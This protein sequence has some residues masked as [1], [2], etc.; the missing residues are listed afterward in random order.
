[1]S[2]ISLS[3]RGLQPGDLFGDYRIVAVAGKGGMGIV[4]KAVHVRLQRLV[5]LKLLRTDLSSDPEFQER[6]LREATL[7]ASIRRHENVVIVYDSGVEDDRLFLAMEWVDGDDLRSILDRDGPFPPVTAVAI[8]LQT[9]HALDAV[10]A[11]MVHRDVKPANIMISDASEAPHVYLTDFGVA[12]P[13]ISGKTLTQ[14]GVPVGTPGYL[15][16]EQALGRRVDQRSDLYS[17]GCVFFEA[18][19][20]WP[21]FSAN[22]DEELDRAH[23][24]STLPSLTPVLGSS[25]EPF[26]R[27]LTTALAIDPDRRQSSANEFAREL[28]AAAIEF[29]GM[30]DTSSVRGPDP[31]KRPTTNLSANIPVAST[32]HRNDVG[33]QSIEVGA[34]ASHPRRAG[35]R[36]VFVTLALVAFIGAT[37]GVLAENGTRKPPPR[38]GPG[39]WLKPVD[40]GSR[41]MGSA[42][43][44]GVD[45]NGN[46]YVF[47][48][49]TNGGLWQKWTFNGSWNGREPIAAAGLGLASQPSVAVHLGGDQDVF[50]KGTNA[51]LREIVYTNAWQKPVRLRSGRLGSPPAA[52]V[53]ANGNVYVF[54][55]GT[56]GALWD[57][58]NLGAGWNGPVELRRAGHGLASQP[59]V[60]VHTG[61]E[62]D[63]FWKGP[64]GQLREMS[65]T[66]VW[67]KPV[68]LRSPPLVSAPTAGVDA[69][70]NVYVF[71]TGTN[72]TLWQKWNVD[73]HWIR[74]EPVTAARHGLTAQPAVAVDGDGSLDVFWKTRDGTLW[75][76]SHV[77]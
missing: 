69:K 67:Q 1:M 10:H 62:Q 4:Y 11:T 7:A 68:T 57:K 66:N 41:P 6:F 26:D 8:V 75:E 52:G 34:R 28:E 19:T 55:R 16:P 49:G 60:A 9:A 63:V 77:N 36:I 21:V 13:T 17:L 48:T 30:S 12:R 3:D 35:K 24:L 54:W 43:T 64:S 33:A 37:V 59:A 73:G 70:G 50:W 58:W 56:N 15:A 23:A 39:F 20:G 29:G 14:A 32:E 18:V 42:P 71:W 65:R 76:I 38:P 22:N 47:W 31:P 46:V 51:H 27:F 74:S 72:G 61:G 2:G 40:L 53:D 44:A 25:F 5:A 45:A